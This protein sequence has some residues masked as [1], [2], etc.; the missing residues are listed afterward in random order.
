MAGAEGILEVDEDEV[1]R[2]VK[3]II[4]INQE[5]HTPTGVF[6]AKHSLP[7]F[8]STTLCHNWTANLLVIMFSIPLQC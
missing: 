4:T 1:E 3:I 2:M 7:N 5:F 8:T 6:A